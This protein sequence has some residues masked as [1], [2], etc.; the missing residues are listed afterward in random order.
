M[1]IIQ[2]ERRTASGGLEARSPVGQLEAI[3]RELEGWARAEGYVGTRPRVDRIVREC[4]AVSV[5]APTKMTYEIAATIGGRTVGAPVRVEYEATGTVCS[6][7]ATGSAGN[8]GNASSPSSGGNVSNSGNSGC[9]VGRGTGAR[10]GAGGAA[11]CIVALAV[12]MRR[13]SAI[14]ISKP[15]AARSFGRRRARASIGR[16]AM[17]RAP[18]KAR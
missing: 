8:A 6:P 13:R 9:A 4:N 14:E 17:D 15:K 18:S 12:L 10:S 1:P 5:G 7:N 11:L 2:F 16:S 3:P